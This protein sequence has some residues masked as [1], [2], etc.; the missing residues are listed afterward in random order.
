MKKLALVSSLVLSSASLS[1]GV[2]VPV[3]ITAGFD[4]DVVADSI[5]SPYGTSGSIDGT[6]WVFVADSSAANPLPANGLVTIGSNQYQLGPYSANNA[7]QVTQ[8]GNETLTINPTILSSN[9]VGVLYASGNGNVPGS[10]KL[11]FSDNSSETI[12]GLSFLDWYSGGPVAYTRLQTSNG[13]MQQTFTV[14]EM[15]LSLN[16]GNVGKTLVSLEFSNLA[17]T[18]APTLN[19][20]AVSVAVP[21]PSTYA[22]LLGLAALGLVAYRRRRR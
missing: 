7:M 22:I 9:E 1:L 15:L 13:A 19:V 2:L 6:G 5:T 11:N 20:F 12:T 8:N 21:E 14:R 17:P 4:V 10:V 3:S 18:A 16:P